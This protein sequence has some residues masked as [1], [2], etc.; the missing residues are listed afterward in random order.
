MRPGFFVLEGVEGSGKSTLIKSLYAALESLDHKVILTREPGG[1]QLGI[2]IREILLQDKTSKTS[3]ISELLLF[4]ADR[5]QHLEE[6]IKPSIDENKIILCDRFIYSTIAY[7]CFGRGLEIS[8]IKSLN[9]LVVSDHTPQGVILLDIDPNISLQRV[10]KRG[11]VDNF[12]K[13]NLEFHQRIRRGYLE[14]SKEFP[15]IFFVIDANKS[16]EEI[17]KL[18]LEFITTKLH[19]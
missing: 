16:P 15:E 4:Y 18:A 9:K 13:E 11:E 14:L 19:S 12:E 5:A 17:L 6:V 8:L 2:K 7:Q 10:K 1:T 3:P